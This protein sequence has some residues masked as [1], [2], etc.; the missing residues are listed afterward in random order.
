MVTR[1]CL[2]LTAPPGFRCLHEQVIP[3]PDS[4]QNQNQVITGFVIQLVQAS[5]TWRLL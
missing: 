1:I 5:Q 4:F 2:Q 3:L